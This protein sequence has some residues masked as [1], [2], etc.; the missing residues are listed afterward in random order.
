MLRIRKHA[1]VLLRLDGIKS[2]DDDDDDDDEDD[3]GLSVS[4]ASAN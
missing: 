3:D 2:D 1:F 4:N